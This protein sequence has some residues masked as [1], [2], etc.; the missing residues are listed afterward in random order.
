M[1]RT[2]GTNSEKNGRD[3]EF[4]IINEHTVIAHVAAEESFCAFEK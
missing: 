3:G 1:I 2:N 4:E